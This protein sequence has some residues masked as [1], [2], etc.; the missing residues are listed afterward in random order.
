MP[1]D[2]FTLRLSAKELN[3][4]LRGG[5]ISK[6]VQPSREEVVF[7]I[8]TDRTT[9]KLKLNVNASDCGVYFTER[10]VEAPLVAPN[11]CMLLRKHLVNAEI[12]AVS[13]VGFER[14]VKFTLACHSDF[15]E[16]TRELYVEV[17]GKYSNTILT[18]RGVILGALKTT[19]LDLSAKRMILSGV[20][21]VLP[22]AQGKADPSDKTALKAALENTAGDL[23]KTLFDRVAGLA[24]HTAQCIAR[25]YAGG[26]LSEHVY[27]YIF[28][29]GISP[30]VGEKDFYARETN[31]TPFAT[32]LEAQTAFYDE[33]SGRKQRE[34]KR[35]SLQAVCASAL[36]KQ[37]KRLAQTVEKRESCKDYELL[38]VK[39]ELLTANLYKIERGMKGV[40]VDN[41]YDGSKLKIALDSALSPAQNA[42]NYYKRYRKQKR[43]LEFLLPQ[44]EE[45]KREIEYLKTLA[46]AVASA[47]DENDLSSIEE[48]ML[49]AKLLLPPKEKR[50]KTD[51]E[52][53]FRSYEKDG[54]TVLAGRNNLQ[55]EKL[56]RSSRPDDLWLH[57]QKYH[58]C[59]VVIKTDGKNVPDGVLLFAAGICARYSDG[60]AGKIPVDYCKVK[61]VKKPPKTKPGF[62]IYTDY[63]TILVESEPR[64]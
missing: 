22:A 42:Q 34:S 17:M 3:G 28:S 47:V 8:Y 59:H 9:L 16:C 6:I 30:R 61:Y 53:G 12:L 35:K 27:N 45:T 26:D 63:K 7:Y 52:I 55:N 5:K 36:K 31:G 54:F 20:P 2:A 64:A 43:T 15:N 10:E 39:G 56:V 21:Y 60:G 41:Y 51:T 46:A 1:Q 49:A 14:I 24:P 13:L 11:F 19:S 32:L 44:E 58:S 37:E 38:R 40:E 29:D 4:R 62:V 23:E 18:E 50:K 48:G 57:A 25:S 33:R